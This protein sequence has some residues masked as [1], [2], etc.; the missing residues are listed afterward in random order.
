MRFSSWRARLGR[1]DQWRG[2]RPPFNIFVFFEAFVQ[3]RRT[4]QQ[5]GFHAGCK[6]FFELALHEAPADTRT[7]ASVKPATFPTWCYM[8]Q[9]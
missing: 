5:L 1:G 3:R 6:Y 4:A 2:S 9:Q 8:E 7:E